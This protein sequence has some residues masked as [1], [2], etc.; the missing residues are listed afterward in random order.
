MKIV[1]PF[2]KPA[3]SQEILDI[4][5]LY[6]ADTVTELSKLGATCAEIRQA[7]ARLGDPGCFDTEPGKDMSPRASRVY[8]ILLSGQEHPATYETG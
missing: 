3:T 7:K 5:K 4:L 1:H 8:E 6:A 2:E